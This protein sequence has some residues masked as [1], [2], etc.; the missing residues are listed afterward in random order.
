METV[1]RLLKAQTDVMA[2]QAKAVAVQNLPNLSCYTGEG[3]DATDDGFDRWVQRFRERARFASWSAKDQLYQLKL[4]L[5]K[6]ALDVFRMLPDSECDTIDNAIQALKKRFKPKYIEELR[7]LEFHHRTQG[8]ESIEQLGIGIQQLGRKAF[9][10][11]Q[12]F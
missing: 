12:G 6:T 4:R 9:H 5:D 7:G 11:R 3:G 10:N 8:N 1:T 2:A